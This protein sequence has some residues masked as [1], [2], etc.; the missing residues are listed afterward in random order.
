MLAYGAAA[1]VYGPLARVY[2]SRNIELIFFFIFCLANLYAGLAQTF[3]HFLVARL[4]MGLSG[5]SVIPLVLV[6]IAAQ[7]RQEHRG[8]LVGI[9]FSATFAASLIGLFLSG[10]V[11]WRYLYIAPA[12]LGLLLWIALSI[13]L[14]SFRPRQ[15][16]AGQSYLRVIRD[17]R[18]RG[19]F[20]YIFT[21]SLLYHGVQQ[22]L[23]VYFSS[24]LGFDQFTVSMLI[25]LTALSGIFGEVIGGVAADT[26]GRGRIVSAGLLIMAGSVFLLMLQVP[27]AAAAAIMVVWGLGWTCNH[28]GLS[29]LLTD[30]PREVLNE[31]ASMNSSIRFLSGGAGTLAA[32]MLMSRSFTL[33]FLVF[34]AALLG[35]LFLKPVRTSE[36]I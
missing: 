6:A 31:A 22:W 33:G 3:G 11:R 14:P 34:G 32:G 24:A 10:I 1:L 12:L 15:D 16:E 21:V 27:L 17:R 4:L 13:Y 7:E 25:T 30:L 9:F 8:T 35:L 28:A 5:A 29:A 36:V 19:L 18:V 2:D 23:A 20:T 26:M